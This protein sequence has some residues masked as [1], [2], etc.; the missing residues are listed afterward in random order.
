M[1]SAD[2]T[3]GTNAGTPSAPSFKASPPG[4]EQALDGAAMLTVLTQN[5][6]PPRQAAKRQTKSIKNQLN[7]RFF[8][9]AM[10]EFRLGSTGHAC[11]SGKSALRSRSTG[12]LKTLI[13]FS[14]ERNYPLRPRDKETP[15]ALMPRRLKD[16]WPKRLGRWAGFA[17]EPSALGVVY[18]SIW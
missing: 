12:T 2:T 8:C 11:R 5:P 9:N 1:G 10:V 6:C 4:V 18:L 15:V 14:A 13:R 17:I 16:K 7:S 3:R